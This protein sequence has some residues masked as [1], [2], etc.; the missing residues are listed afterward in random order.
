VGWC[1]KIDHGVSLAN[2]ANHCSQ[3]SHQAVCSRLCADQRASAVSYGHV[4]G[5]NAPE[6]DGVSVFAR[7][8]SHILRS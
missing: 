3:C 1:F 2:P 6:I 5:V 8:V 4:N 7:L